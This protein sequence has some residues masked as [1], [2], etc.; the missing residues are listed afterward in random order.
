MFQQTHE[1]PFVVSLHKLHNLNPKLNV[2]RPNFEC[3]EQLLEV[4]NQ[5]HH[6]TRKLKNWLYKIIFIKKP[7]RS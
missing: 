4:S 5:F 3:M 1:C 7:D 6:P 2:H